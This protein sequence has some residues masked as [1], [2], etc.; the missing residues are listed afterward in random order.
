MPRPRLLIRAPYLFV[1]VAFLLAAGAAVPLAQSTAPSPTIVALALSGLA[2]AIAMTLFVV[3]ALARHARDLTNEINGVTGALHGERQTHN[4]TKA[5]AELRLK[6][7]QEQRRLVEDRL[8]SVLRGL[9]GAVLWYDKGGVVVAAEGS[10]LGTLFAGEAVVGRKVQDLKARHANAE[11]NFRRAASGE[12]FTAIEQFPDLRVETRYLPLREGKHV[13]GVLAIS[14][15]LRER[16]RLEL[17]LRESDERAR[18]MFEE[19]PVAA[20][21]VGTDDRILLANHALANALGIDAKQ[22]TSLS[23]TAITHPE[24]ASAD[25]PVRERLLRGEL[26]VHRGARRLVRKDGDVLSFDATQTVLRDPQGRPLYVLVMLKDATGRA[27][28]EQVAAHYARHDPTTDLP[29]RVAFEERLDQTLA[30]MNVEKQRLGLVAFDVVN[31]GD[32]AARLGRGASDAILREIARRVG[33]ALSDAD[34]LARTGRGQFAL[35][36]PRR[37]AA[38]T[39]EVVEKLLSAV[40]DGFAVEGERVHADLRLGFAMY[41]EDAGDGEQLLRRAEAALH[42]AKKNDRRYI[43]Y[44]DNVLV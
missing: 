11:W 12:E 38:G 23:F 41:P 14:L 18:R 27:H 31:L 36:V 1:A 28:D 8:G 7:A 16:D 32:V 20:A 26:P 4:D 35:A 37:G 22:L 13:S 19:M 42:H 44:G 2:V 5:D 10:A 33:A 43:R 30:K 39:A 34:V 17:A 3:R 40:A 6:V 24:D 15:D 21:F 9:P 29:N 25:K